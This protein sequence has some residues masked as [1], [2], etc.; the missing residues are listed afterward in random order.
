V[1]RIIVDAPPAQ[2]ITWRLVHELAGAC[3]AAADDI[4]VRVVVLES[5]DPAFWLTHFDV[6]AI[7][8]IPVDGPA[9]AR[10]ELHA[11]YRACLA[12]RTSPVP[13]IALIDGRV[14][15]GGAELAAALD[16]RF[17]SLERTV[18]TQMEVPL[19][20]VPGGGG[21]QLLPELVGR[22]RA[23]EMVLGGTEVD[24]ARAEAWGWLNRALPAAELRPFVDELA[25]RI[26]TFDP[27]VVRRAKRAVAL[28]DQAAE[29]TG[30]LR[31]EALLFDE[32]IRLPRSAAS[33]RRFLD[34]GGQTPEGEQR[35]GPLAAEAASGGA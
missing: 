13:S 2:V 19:G 11:F 1:G 23:L 4:D 9:E 14:G 27:A 3:T 8:A 15:G 10:S 25:A 22:G 21:T 30:R 31:T 34:L 7:L 20:I 32:C 29:L 28:G 6:E 24:A 35:V 33:M 5:A 12:F 17:G 18:V 16:M 26:A